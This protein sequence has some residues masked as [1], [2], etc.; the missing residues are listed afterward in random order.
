MLV[1]IQLNC[2]KGGVSNCF[3]RMEWR[4]LGLGELLDLV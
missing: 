2:M 1:S 4:E 3:W